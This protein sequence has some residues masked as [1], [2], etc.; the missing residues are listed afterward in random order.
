[1]RCNLCDNT[2]CATCTDSANNCITDCY[3]S[4]K[5]CGTNAKCTKCVLEKYITSQGKCEACDNTKCGTC[6]TS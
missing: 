6:K 2:V 4:C 5:E 1:M 3:P